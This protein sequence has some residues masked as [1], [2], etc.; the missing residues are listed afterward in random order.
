M[1]TPPDPLDALR[2][3]ARPVAP[4][5]AFAVRLRERVE[6]LLLDPSR[7]IEED[8]M[9]DT[10]T[11]AVRLRPGDLSYTAVWTPD[12]AAAE[13][14]YAA[15]LGWE[16]EGDHDGRGR[17]VTNL[18]TAMGI[19]GGM[20]STLFFAAVV[21]DA[22][23][24]AERVRAAGGTAGDPTDMP[25]GRLV[26]CH[27]DQGLAFALH[28]PAPGGSTI[29]PDTGAAGELAYVAVQ[30]PDTERARAFYGSVLGWEFVAGTTPGNWHVEVGGEPTRPAMVGLGRHPGPPVVLPM[31]SVT[32]VH[33]AL[34]AV[35]AAGGTAAEPE[36]A[37]YGTV[38][39]CTDD[40][41]GRFYLAR[42]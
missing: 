1:S 39:E 13:R 41:G 34:D 24:A 40:Q 28:Q 8:D 5:P 42:F 9:T 32:D 20:P 17:R 21:E 25:Y 16:T 23:A 19:F 11:A 18:R 6:A 29:G 31:F 30:T 26:D 27:D 33:A 3:P 36:A 35:R 10:T 4:D 2:E 22:D 38:S 15:V 37:G 14:F 7:T 12:A